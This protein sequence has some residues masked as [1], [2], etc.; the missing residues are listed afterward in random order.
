M[1]DL[2]F[3]ILYGVLAGVLFASFR[4]AFHDHKLDQIPVVGSSGL[5]ASYWDAFNSIRHSPDFIQCGYKLYPDRIFRVAR[6]F[7]WEYVVCSP[8]LT[9]DIASAPEHIISFNEAENPYHLQVVR[10]TL[11]RNLHVCFLDVRDEI[12]CA[13]DD[14]LQLEGLDWK[15]LPMLPTMMAIV[16]HMSNQG[17]VGIRNSYMTSKSRNKEYLANS[18]NH[19]IDI[20]RSARKI[21]VVPPFLRPLLGP[22]ISTQNKSNARALQFLG[23]LIEE[24][25][26]KERELGRDWPG[27]PNDL[28]SWVLDLAETEQRAVFPITV[29]IM[30]MNMAAI[31]TTSMAATYAIFD[32]MTRPE[33]LLP[34]RE[35]AERVVKEKGWTKTALNNMVK[36]DSFLRESQRLNTNG[37]AGM[38]RKVVAKDGFRFSDGTVLPYGTFLSVARAP[39]RSRLRRIDANYENAATFDGFRFARERA[40][41]SKRHMISTAVDHMPF[42]TGKH[43]C[44]GRFFAATELK[45]MMAHLVI[46]YDVKAE[47]VRPADKVFGA[48][49][50]PDAD[51]KVR[52]RK[53]Q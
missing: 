50:F 21:S 1:D 41:H 7:Q 38:W 34:M 2:K 22:L 4:K 33:Y 16:A 26:S 35:E 20:M 11:T 27:K 14:V 40:E 6:L 47:G 32:L 30:H 39:I 52:V 3:L 36:I 24:G 28:V 48:L 15:I 37:P 51:G 49:Y 23:P 5:L 10:S 12:V 46:N 29:R 31:H 9:R 42:G 18:V 44:P 17:A 53:R 13:F 43:A 8:K 19:T 25:L 45:A